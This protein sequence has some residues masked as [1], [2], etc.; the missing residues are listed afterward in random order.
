[1]LDYCRISVKFLQHSAPSI[2][3]FKLYMPTCQITISHEQ[4]KEHSGNQC[5]SVNYDNYLNAK[6]NKCVFVCLDDVKL[7]TCSIERTVVLI[8]Q[9]KYMHDISEWNYTSVIPH[10]TC[11]LFVRPG[12]ESQIA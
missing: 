11:L 3:G 9:S 5:L 6:I 7:Y 12:A 1:M 10:N 8:C 4:N 2:T